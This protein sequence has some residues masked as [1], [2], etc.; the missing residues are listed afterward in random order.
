MR[1]ADSISRR[2]PPPRRARAREYFS[3]YQSVVECVRRPRAVLLLVFS[4]C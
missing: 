1:S 3:R 2:P 4:L